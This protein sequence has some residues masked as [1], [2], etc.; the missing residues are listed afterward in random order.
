MK[1]LANKAVASAYNKLGKINDLLN[2]PDPRFVSYRENGKD[3]KIENLD[4]NPK[5]CHSYIGKMKVDG[6]GTYSDE[7]ITALL[8]YFFDHTKKWEKVVIELANRVSEIMNWE[9]SME[10]NMNYDEQKEHILEFAKIINKKRVWDLE[11]VNIENN[12][13]RLFELLENEWIKWLESDWVKI[14]LWENFD[15]L[16][17]AR[18]L[19]NVAKNDEKYLDEIR[20]LKW[21]ELKKIEWNSD[22]YGLIEVAI[23]I[24][25]ILHGITLQWWVGRQKKYDALLLKHINPY[26]KD[27]P[28]LDEFKKFCWEKL[29]WE[30]F[31]WLYFDT[32]KSEDLV[33]KMAAKDRLKAKTRSALLLALWLGIWVWGTVLGSNYLQSQK[34]KKATQET[35]KEIFEN[36]KVNW[37]GEYWYGEYVWKEKIEKINEYAQKVYDRFL[38]RYGST[39]SFWEKEF[40]SKIIDCLNNQKIL[41]KLWYDDWLS[42]TAIEDIIIDDYLIPQNVWELKMNN[43]PVSPYESLVPYTDEFI[44]TILLEDDFEIKA[45][46]TKK[47]F[48]DKWWV[49]VFNIP[50][51]KDAWLFS[52]KE[53][54]WKS[55]YSFFKNKFVVANHNWNRYILAGNAYVDEPY[56]KKEEKFWT[57]KAKYLAL[58]FMEQTNPILNLVL[59]QYLLRYD[60]LENNHINSDG[61]YEKNN[62]RISIEM[63]IIR[64]FLKK[65]LLDKIWKKFNVNDKVEKT[66]KIN[67]FLDEFVK[68][69]KSKLEELS[70]K[71]KWYYDE[72]NPEF[73]PNGFFHK[74][75][76]AIENT[77]KESD[78]ILN[79]IGRLPVSSYEKTNTVDH[80][81]SYQ[82]EDGKMYKVWIVNIWDKRYLFADDELSINN[83]EINYGS[84]E[85]N[86]VA[87]DYMKQ[88]KP[89]IKNLLDLYLSRYFNG[90]K[91]EERTNTMWMKTF[92]DISNKME[93]M[94][95]KD[96]ISKWLLEKLWSASDND[97]SQILFSYIDKFVKDNIVELKRLSQYDDNKTNP[98]MIPNFFLKEYE[99][100]MKNTIVNKDKIY[101]DASRDVT[102]KLFSRI[103]KYISPDWKKYLVWENIIEWI[104]YICAKEEWNK[105]WD[106][107]DAM[108]CGK[109]VAEDYFRSKENLVK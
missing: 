27:F 30:S 105:N 5:H 53:L 65:W 7:L 79:Q 28:L 73:L 3:K 95:I 101:I 13:T 26:I 70:G 96:F 80:I 25:A 68:E 103:W 74:Y 45:D 50:V 17:I 49:K 12:N 62:I 83:S 6:T 29:K 38:F 99:W 32:E 37:A 67:D 82:T 48:D 22:Y 55:G 104:S 40:M 76:D 107:N 10:W 102:N 106:N 75:E 46:S 36:K 52:S 15:S 93:E 18:I 61:Q 91:P 56:E 19:Y 71:N 89:I 85:W 20:D 60:R 94:I 51:T 8:K 81:W 72:A 9:E 33:K 47:V 11:I 16:D 63:L 57:E 108:A 2:G 44:N 43:V 88:S 84:H 24:N 69:N 64:D 42:G 34:Q 14:N 87:I 23:R 92:R 21:E 59:D 4:L 98:E 31:K 77:I 100:A 39:W 66:K 41:D 58:D 97:K 86:E 90:N 35:I 78:W 1:S 54:G 109:I